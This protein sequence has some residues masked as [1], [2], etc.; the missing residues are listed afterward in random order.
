MKHLKRYKIFES[1]DSELESDVK[2]MFLELKDEGFGVDVDL[3]P[4][5]RRHHLDTWIIQATRDRVFNWSDVSDTFE[6]AKEHIEN[7]GRW[8]IDRYCIY[9]FSNNRD[10]WGDTW[11]K[12]RR[13]IYGDDYNEFIEFVSSTDQIYEICFIFDLVK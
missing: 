8:K 3:K 5:E 4:S 10:A 11:G 12:R 13:D 1:S 9:Y 6:R 7:S 2:D